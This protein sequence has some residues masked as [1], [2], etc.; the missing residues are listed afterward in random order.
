MAQERESR[1]RIVPSTPTCWGMVDPFFFRRTVRVIKSSSQATKGNTSYFLVQGMTYNPEKRR[2]KTATTSRD[3]V[4]VGGAWAALF[5]F[6]SFYLL[7]STLLYHS[8]YRYVCYT[9]VSL[10]TNYPAHRGS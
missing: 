2:E 4:A 1:P 7:C 3:D 6:T 8:I 9:I 5:C 10:S